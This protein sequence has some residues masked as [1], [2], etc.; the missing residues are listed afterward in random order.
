MVQSA[1][2]PRGAYQRWFGWNFPV[3]A[4]VQ[5][6]RTVRPNY[7]SARQLKVAGR[8]KCSFL[9]SDGLV[10]CLW[11]VAVGHPQNQVPSER[12]FRE[13]VPD[14]IGSILWCKVFCETTGIG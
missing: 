5:T 11:D 6:V 10:R 2:S 12:G 3:V 14:A 13:V 4:Q 1:P 7:K 8:A 9:P